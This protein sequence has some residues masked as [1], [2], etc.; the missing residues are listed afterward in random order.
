[1]NQR[2]K[3]GQKYI[4]R[5]KRQDI[6]TVIDIHKTFNNA[7][8]LVKLRY[9]SQHNFIGQKMTDYDVTDTAIARGIS[10]EELQQVIKEYEGAK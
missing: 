6:C 7:G 9:V 2:F 3:I 4:L 8:E 5:G 10:N 1:M